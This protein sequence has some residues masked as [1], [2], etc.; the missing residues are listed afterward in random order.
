VKIRYDPESDALV[1]HL[2]VGT[3]VEHTEALEDDERILI[4]YDADNRAVAFE[5]L[6]ATE[7]LGGEVKVELELPVA[8]RKSPSG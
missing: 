5:I 6:E 7:V 4:D 2:R 3:K 8:A 1:I